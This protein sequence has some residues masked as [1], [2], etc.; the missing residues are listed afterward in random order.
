[1]KKVILFL[2]FVPVS[3]SGQMIENF[4]TGT[5]NKWVESSAGRWKADTAGAL[6]GRYSLHHVFDNPDSGNDQTGVPVTNLEPSMGTVKWSFKIR[7]GYDPSSSNNWGVFLISDNIPAAMAPGGPVNGY[8]IGVNLT[9]YD[10]SLRLMKVKNGALSAVL[11]TGINWQNDIGSASAAN[12]IVERSQTGQWKTRVESGAGVLID[13][14]S[15]TDLELFSAE[16]FGVYY[17]YSST[18]DRLLWIDDINIDG[19]FYEDTKPPEVRKCDV[20]TIHSVNLTLDEQPGAAFFSPSNFLLNG[21]SEKARSVLIIS[22]CSV[23]ISFENHFINKSEN[24]L[25]INSL[26]DISANCSQN[27]PVKFTPVLP[28]TGDVVISEIMADPLP[29]VSLPGK[30]YL[31]IANTTNFKFNL[32]NWKLTSDGQ[33][34]SLGETI[35]YPYERMV[36][37]QLQDTG[38][39]RKFGRVTGVKSFPVL[40]DAGRL[41][42][43]SDSSGEMIHGVEYSSEWYGDKVKDD[44]GWSLEM[45]DTGFPFYSEGNWTASI[46]QSGGT[47]GMAN[48]VNRSNPDISFAGITNAF[49]GDSSYL[50]LSFSEPVKNL[51]ETY[52][53]IRINGNK[54][55]SVYPVDP[56]MR[57]YIIR[58]ASPFY[59]YQKYFIALPST[60]T[61]FAGNFPDAGSFTFGIPGKADKGD[62]VFNEIMFNPL[63]GDADYIEL[64]NTSSKIIDASDLSIVS[65]NEYGVYSSPVS[66]S[67]INRC[68]LPGSYYAVSTIKES[69]IKRYFSAI[70]D[71]IFQISQL[72]SMPDDKGRLL[73]FN[74]QLEQIDEVSYNEN[75]HYSLLSGF[76]GISLEKVRPSV[77]SSDPENWHSASE[78]S[79]WGTPGAPNSIYSEKP[80][81]DDRIIYSSTKITPDNDGYED[82]L[83]IDFRLKENSNVV[84]ITIFD[85]TG[86]FV[87]K[88]AENLFAGSSA[89]VTWDGTAENGSLVN[90][91]IYI[92]LITVFDDTGKTGKWKKVCTVIR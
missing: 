27:V 83:V 37:C 35:I 1:M 30:E 20:Y 28:E 42:V 16:W 25:I 3:L 45:I 47:P 72:P 81:S 71:N 40:T 66:L 67:D 58:P 41:L 89:T 2:L 5:L 49:P 46:S 75:M 12:V 74:R 7:H 82:L 79:G 55:D 8:V 15:G 53:E 90:P 52:S 44:G 38:L 87:R 92:V 36:L 9:G 69:I 50:Q 24:I 39:F 78:A 85:E 61:D 59:R 13:S 76:E 56:L 63:P 10:D 43:L 22:P 57:E 60:V 70:K 64:F 51:A 23:R 11:N 65:V 77:P 48:S 91:G 6:S 34:A 29:F 14:A 17:K 80:S 68:I 33:S 54:V 19:V 31:E 4:E 86:G 88:L 73:I 62:I 26:C 84:S 18:R 21:T 32:K